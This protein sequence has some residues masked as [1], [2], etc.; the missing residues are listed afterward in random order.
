[1]HVGDAEAAAHAAYAA[2]HAK[3]AQ[4]KAKTRAKGGLKERL[5]LRHERDLPDRA[6]GKQMRVPPIFIG[7]MAVS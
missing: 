1:M 6:S 5:S 7:E 4:A 2:M 3:A